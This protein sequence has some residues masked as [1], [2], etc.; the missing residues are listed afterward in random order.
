MRNKYGEP[1]S[2]CSMLIGCGSLLIVGMIISLIIMW[3]ALSAYMPE[4]SARSLGDQEE[5]TAYLQSVVETVTA[6]IAGLNQHNLNILSN[7]A[8]IVILFIVFK[9]IYKRPL[10][11][12]GLPRENWLKPLGLGCLAAIIAISLYALIV[13]MSGAAIF[14][15]LDISKLYSADILSA[16]IFFISV[17]FYEE[18]LCRGFLMTVLKTTRNNWVVIAVPAVIFGLMH[19]M[20]PGVTLLGIINI[21][22]IGLAFAYM[23]IKTGSLWMPIGFHIMWNFFQGN[24]YGIQVSGLEGTSLTQYTPTGPDI[25]TGGAFGAEG[26]LICTVIII[27]VLAYIHFGLSI[28]EPPVWTTDS[29]LPFNTR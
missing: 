3:T 26:G 10:S 25:L 14:T 8:Q 16:F 9:L 12:L 20:N 7:A 24:I 11:Q 17:G 19:L 2:G 28:K 18:I 6:D 5:F 21:I 13:Y 15:G 27:A 22:L 29:D 1:K 4:I 23:F